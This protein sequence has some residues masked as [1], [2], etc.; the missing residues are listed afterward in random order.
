MVKYKKIYLDHFGLNEFEFIIDEYEFIV[1]NR[2][3]KAVH[4]HHIEHGANKH[5]HI[6]NL[7]AVSFETHNKAHSEKLKRDYLKD[8]HCIF[9]VRNPY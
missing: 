8:V 7:M 9:M 5:D 3:V 2:V 6:D 4:I 1:N